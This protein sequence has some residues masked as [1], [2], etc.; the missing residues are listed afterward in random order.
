VGME[1]L[2]FRW[3]SSTLPTI[4]GVYIEKRII[5]PSSIS[6]LAAKQRP[7]CY[8]RKVA[9]SLIYRPPAECNISLHSCLYYTRGEKNEH[10]C[11]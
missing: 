5:P 11:V 4:P 9:M 6:F 1:P 8:P 2:A 10:T 3:Q 7:S